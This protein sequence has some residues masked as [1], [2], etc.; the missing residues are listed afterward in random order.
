MSNT[1]TNQQNNIQTVP[2]MNT[3]TT[4]SSV[5]SQYGYHLS[6]GDTERLKTLQ[7]G[8]SMVVYATG[9]RHGALLEVTYHSD[10]TYTVRSLTPLRVGDQWVD[11]NQTVR[12][13]TATIGYSSSGNIQYVATTGYSTTGNVYLRESGSPNSNVLATYNVNVS[14][15]ITHQTTD[16][17][18]RFS[19]GTPQVTTTLQSI[20]VP[21]SIQEQLQNRVITQ[22]QTNNNLLFGYSSLPEN[23]LWFGYSRV[24]STNTQTT[25]ANNQTNLL[26]NPITN[27]LISL[28]VIRNV[29]NVGRNVYHTM[30][31]I[32]WG[33]VW[34][35]LNQP[36]L[37]TP[38]GER[39]NV[40][41]FTMPPIGPASATGIANVIRTGGS[42]LKS[43]PLS[44]PTVKELAK[45]Y[46]IN[47]A[48]FTA[49]NLGI[50]E[51]YSRLTTGKGLTPEQIKQIVGE[52][53]VFGTA[54]TTIGK[55]FS[56]ASQPVLSTIVKQETS[57]TKA[58]LAKSLYDVSSS[59]AAGTGASFASQG[60]SKAIGWRE[61]INP[62]EAL[63]VGSLTGGVT[64][65]IRGF[66]VLRAA[67][68]GDYRAFATNIVPIEAKTA[69][70]T[71]ISTIITKDGEIITYVAGRAQGSIQIGQKVFTQKDISNLKPI[72]YTFIATERLRPTHI[73]YTYEGNM[74]TTKIG[75]EG[76]YIAQAGVKRMIGKIE[77][78]QIESI[79]IPTNKVNYE[80]YQLLEQSMIKY[81]T[82]RY[83]EFAQ[84]QNIPQESMTIFKQ[85]MEGR[86]IKTVQNPNIQTLNIYY[87]LAELQTGNVN[88]NKGIA[89]IL[90]FR[91]RGT[92]NIPGSERYGFTKEGA[93]LTY[94]LEEGKNQLSTI[95]TTVGVMRNQYGKGW[96][97]IQ[98]FISVGSPEKVL[99]H[100]V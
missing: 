75:Y 93:G 39:A 21:T 86:P 7:P 40:V 78:V 29:Y 47:T 6:Y 34:K 5:L 91:S 52:S 65:A 49:L 90:L 33:D 58:I 62:Y 84:L 70:I 27:T 24:P 15:P 28:P 53:I 44:S 17:G 97:D 94:Y 18:I 25:N 76:Q 95:G 98:K 66:Q 4:V 85:I 43:T 41:S 60:F 36:E 81:Y 50:N 20:N 99:V 12:T 67:K 23:N 68:T 37:R 32:D 30:S 56:L 96:Y 3:P 55:G 38:T 13:P 87:P 73:A 9:G 64:S 19:V 82:K 89:G 61:D 54:Y 45:E 77:D 35:R 80:R 79:F 59:F 48:G 26:N 51:A 31:S 63:A 8:Q 1:L 72:E 69:D 16:T 11:I 100:W 42:T 71:P 92:I 14:V 74:L 88:L 10:G 2:L 83:P 46:A 22:S 57:P